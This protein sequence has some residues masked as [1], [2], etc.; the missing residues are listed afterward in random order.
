MFISLVHPGSTV[1]HS[2]CGSTR[3]FLPT[4]AT[5]HGPELGLLFVSAAAMG[6][7]Y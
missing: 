3:S 1:I 6:I 2:V 7:T 4:L 5:V